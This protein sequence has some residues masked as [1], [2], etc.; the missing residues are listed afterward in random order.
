MIHEWFASK[1]LTYLSFHYGRFDSTESRVLILRSTELLSLYQKK[2]TQILLER[3]EDA[4]YSPWDRGFDIS[5]QTSSR[6]L[7]VY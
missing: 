1:V 6:S 5:I 2:R 4:G 3:T 7:P